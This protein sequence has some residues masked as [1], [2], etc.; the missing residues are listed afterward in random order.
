[1]QSGGLG[2][3]GGGCRLKGGGEGEGLSDQRNSAMSS[4]HHIWPEGR[5]LSMAQS[6]TWV[7]INRGVTGAATGL[8]TRAGDWREPLEALEDTV[9]V[10]QGVGRSMDIPCYLPPK[11]ES[12]WSSPR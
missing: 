7:E 4:S 9:P 1:M 8:I 2:T 11:G 5:V 3:E 12:A 6:S 10:S